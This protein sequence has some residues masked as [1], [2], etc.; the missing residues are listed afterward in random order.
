ML[1][2]RDAQDAQLQFWQMLRED[3]RLPKAKTVRHGWNY[4]LASAVLTTV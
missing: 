3:D 4:S 2:S 1:G